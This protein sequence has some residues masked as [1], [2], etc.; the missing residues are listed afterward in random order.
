MRHL[1]KQ[2]QR[3]LPFAE[4]ADGPE[5]PN[6]VQESCRQLLAQLLVQVANVETNGRRKGERQD[7]VKSS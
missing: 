4:E 2:R 5:L 6:E 7:P 3:Q 1:Q